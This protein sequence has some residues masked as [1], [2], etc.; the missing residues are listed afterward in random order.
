VDTFLHSHP[1]SA[2]EFNIFIQN[3]TLMNKIV[4]LISVCLFSFTAVFAQTG[5]SSYQQQV[6]RAEQL[7]KQYPRLVKST[8]LA[9]TAGG[10]EIRMITIGSGD[11]DKKPALAIIGGVEGKHLLGTELALGF[12]EKLL[13]GSN[14][15]SIRNLLDKTTFYVFP[16][17]SPDAME[18]YFAPLKYERSGNA[19]QT[20]DDRDG[21]INEDGFDDLDGNGKIT[22]IRVASPIGEYIQHPDDPSVLIKAD[23]AKGEKGKYIIY[24]EGIDNDKDGEWNEDGEGGVWFN[25]NLSFK[26][27]SFTPGS[28]EFAVSEIETRALLDKLF[29]L[30]NVYAVISFSSQNNLSS[31]LSFNAANTTPRVI[32]GYLEPDVKVNEMVSQWYN[33]TTNMKEAPKSGSPGG[34]FLSWAY[35]H[36]GRFSFGTPGWFVPKAKVD[37][38]K[39]EKPISPDDATVNFIRWSK[40]E[41][42]GVNF[43]PWKKISHPDFPGQEVEVGG[44]D[45]FVMINPPYN[46][47]DGIVKK[48]TEFIVKLAEAQPEIDIAEIKVEKLGGGISRITVSVMNKGLLPSHSK[49]GERSYWIKRINVN[50]GLASSQT[51]VSGKKVQVLNALD[52]LSSREISWLVKGSGKVSIEAGSPTTGRKKTDINL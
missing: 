46:L 20:D 17:M 19:S 40:Q 48:H 29:T 3:I 5:Y 21:K 37:T 26:H 18:Q 8:V 2:R 27:P 25:K 33:K 6:Q 34:D 42:A 4:L 50:L 23:P 9:R 11:I 10:K 49:L 13:A 7:V 31:P 28:G 32:T 43:T 44:I 16:N 45:P 41:N 51:L 14:T 30:F 15:D 1:L 39:K 12:A 52:G 24:S 35:Y 47:V 22:Q 38:S 36:Y